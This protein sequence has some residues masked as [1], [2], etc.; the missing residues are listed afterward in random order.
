MT[1]KNFK[2][3]KNCNSINNLI[4]TTLILALQILSSQFYSFPLL[5]SNVSPFLQLQFEF[6]L[7]SSLIIVFSIIFSPQ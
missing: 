7:Y 5:L 3:Y 2:L 1:K 4:I 6:L